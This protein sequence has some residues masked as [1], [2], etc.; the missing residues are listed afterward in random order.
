AG[1]MLGFFAELGFIFPQFPYVAHSRGWSSEDME[2]NVEI[3]RSSA[4]LAEGAGELAKR[5]IDLAAHLIAQDQAPATIERGGRKAHMLE[6]E[7]PTAA[8]A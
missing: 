7:K 5:C 6:V 2:R 4:E 1:Q 3:V 8:G